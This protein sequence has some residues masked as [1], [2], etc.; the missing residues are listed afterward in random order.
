MKKIVGL[1]FIFMAVIQLAA[2]ADVMECLPEGGTYHEYVTCDA[3]DQLYV[4]VAT[5]TL[6]T[7]ST[8]NVVASVTDGYF[9]IWDGATAAA[10]LDGGTHDALYTALTDGTD[11]ALIDGSGNLNVTGTM[12]TSFGSSTPTVYIDDNGNVIDV[13]STNLDIRDLTAASDAVTIQGG[14]TV[15]VSIDDGGN[16]ITVDGAVTVSATA[17]DIRALTSA[18]VITATG[19]MDIGTGTVNIGNVVQ[20]ADNGGALTVDGTVTTTATDL[21]IR[22]LTSVSDSVAVEGGNTADVKVTL[23]SEAVTVTRLPTP[24][25]KND[26]IGTAAASGTDLDPAAASYKFLVV[27]SS[28]VIVWC[29]TGATPSDGVGIPLLANGGSWSEDNVSVTDLECF[30][31]SGSSTAAVAAVFWR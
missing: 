6:T 27:N 5:G 21:D 10:I 31:P 11:V 2:M 26:T 7:V 30:N 24:E 23:D 29:K 17:L 12:T 3:S 15:D 16:A 14:N 22:D 8:V 18:D 9:H 20:V 19:T 1:I 4:N 28:S 13:Q 25:F